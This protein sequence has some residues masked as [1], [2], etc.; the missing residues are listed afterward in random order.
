MG[1][2]LSIIE[3]KVFKLYSQGRSTENRHEGVVYFGLVYATNRLRASQMLGKHSAT[4]FHLQPRK[5]GGLGR[6]CTLIF[7]CTLFIRYTVSCVALHEYH[8]S[9]R[10]RA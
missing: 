1:L 9:V 6:I 3:Y 2:A 10:R 8:S 4:E 7:A 5:K